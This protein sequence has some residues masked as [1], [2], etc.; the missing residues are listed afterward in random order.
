M[1]NIL[2]INENNFEPQDYTIRKV[3]RLILLDESETK[4]IFFGSMLPG[5]GVEDGETDEQ[6][7]A[8]EAMEEL[9]AT[10]EIIKPVG[11]VVAYRDF[12][13]KKYVQNGYLC[14]QIG[15][16]QKPTSIDP[17]EYKAK[18]EWFDIAEAIQ[19]LRGELD[20]LTNQNPPH[21]DL[22][23]RKIQHRRMTLA[24]LEEITSQK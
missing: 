10:V 13:K 1:K 5:G 2:T 20:S 14:K 11:Q 15:E 3:V 7:L 16:L 22:S 8:R 9:G 18:T 21:D 17:E 12:L 24:F 19:R 23:Q 4:V 6:A